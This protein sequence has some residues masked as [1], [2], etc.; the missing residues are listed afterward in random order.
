VTDLPAS[1]HAIVILNPEAGRRGPVSTNVAATEAIARAL[2]LAG[3]RYELMVPDEPDAIPLLAQTAVER[4]VELVVAAGGDGTVRM[5]A[6]AVIGS[7]AT[8]GILP[9]GSVMNIA[10][11]LEIPREL[12]QAAALLATAPP[13]P[14]DIGEVDGQRFFEG[15]SIGLSSEVFRFVDQ[16]QQGQFSS[17]MAFLRTVR[18]YRPRR[19]RL[20]IDNRP[21]TA[22]ALAVVIANGPYVG[23]GLTVAPDARLD[24][25]LLDVV[26]FRRFS[27]WD[28]LRHFVGIAFG[29]RRYHP[30]ILTLAGRHIRVEARS[31]L[32]VR[33]DGNDLGTTPVE[34]WVVPRAVRVIAGLQRPHP[35]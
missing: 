30:K 23:A 35:S 8:L 18:R 3:L 25:G 26:L 4:G 10:R 14:I 9:L 19:V 22:R 28:L 17:P 1:R 34:V 33:A 13:V 5:V 29:R 6:G 31:P 27:R 24:D 32:P 20:L 11:M 2:D 21:F 12:D 15:V 16:L 7:R